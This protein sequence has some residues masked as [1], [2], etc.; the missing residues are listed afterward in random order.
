MAQH[1]ERAAVHDRR[2]KH[3]D[4]G[5]ADE[6]RDLDVRGRGVQLAR[7]AELQDAAGV[8][9]RDA[10]GHRHGLD[11]VV[12]HVHE[13]GLQALV[14]LGELGAHVDAQLGV[15]VRQWL[16]H[17]E[18]VR[19]A[20]HRAPERHALPLPARELRRAPV[21]ERLD[22]QLRRHGTHFRVDLRASRA[23]GVATGA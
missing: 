22:L 20:N 19:V 18:H 12:R 2:G 15:E 7:R 16:V 9:H 23:G 17:Q 13:G 4:G 14:Q 3:V 21:E 1:V 8:H 5:A 10:I 11:L 6:L